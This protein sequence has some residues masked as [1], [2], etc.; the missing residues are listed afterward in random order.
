MSAV[1]SLGEGNATPQFHKSRNWFSHYMAA[2]RA[3]AAGADP[4]GRVLDSV[5]DAF[6][7]SAFR[8]GLSEVGYVIGRNVVLDVR[9]TNQYDQSPALAMDLVS[10]HPAV[11]VAPGAPATPAVKV[12]TQRFRSYSASVAIPWDWASPSRRQR[13]RHHL[14]HRGASAEASRGHARVVSEGAGVWCSR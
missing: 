3:C 10:G 11:L 9:S 1:L 6:H 5:A 7:F 2:R 8:N 14:L 13:Y 12:A 4:G